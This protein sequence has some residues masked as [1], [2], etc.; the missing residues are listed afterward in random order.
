MTNTVSPK[1]KYS[2]TFDEPSIQNW[3]RLNRLNLS[4]TWTAA[5]YF[6]MMTY[7]LPVNEDEWDA[8]I[9]SHPPFYCSILDVSTLAFILLA[10]CRPAYSAAEPG[11]EEVEKSL[12][13]RS[14]YVLRSAVGMTHVFR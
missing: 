10:I 12:M 13:E 4:S 11:E 7:R 8:D 5:L 9:C 1:R 2:Y 6:F 14:I 3:G